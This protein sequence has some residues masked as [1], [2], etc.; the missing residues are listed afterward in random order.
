MGKHVSDTQTRH[1]EV[2]YVHLQ[3]G[4]MLFLDMLCQASTYLHQASAA[5]GALAFGMI[6]DKHR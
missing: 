2:Y 5:A 1:W 6:V 3:S 4:H